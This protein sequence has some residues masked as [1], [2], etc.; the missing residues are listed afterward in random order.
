MGLKKFKITLNKNML[1]ICSFFSKNTEATRKV[2]SSNET[3]VIKPSNVPKGRA[4]FEE[5]SSRYSSEILNI[6]GHCLSCAMP[7]AQELIASK[8]NRDPH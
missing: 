5:L 8:S 4:L 2:L 1:S 7:C 6:P 3:T